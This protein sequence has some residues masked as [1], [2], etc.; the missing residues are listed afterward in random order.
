[1]HRGTLLIHIWLADLRW[2]VKKLQ[3]KLVYAGVKKIGQNFNLAR[4][5]RV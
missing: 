1:M 2:A 5:S 3:A 4:I